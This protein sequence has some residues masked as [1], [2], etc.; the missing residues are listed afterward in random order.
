MPYVMTIFDYQRLD[1]LA[2]T[3]IHL[4]RDQ[5]VS[6]GAGAPEDRWLR[7]HLVAHRIL[8]GPRAVCWVQTD[9]VDEIHAD[10]GA[11][12]IL[13][14]NAILS[15]RIRLVWGSPAAIGDILAWRLFCADEWARQFQVPWD[16]LGRYLLRTETHPRDQSLWD[17][18]LMGP[19]DMMSPARL[20]TILQ[21]AYP[22][23]WD[24]WVH[25]V[26]PL[27]TIASL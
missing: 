17:Q 14:P 24:R 21:T 3:L 23:V 12:A 11:M 2:Q 26:G 15:A 4:R 7:A 20:S 8:Q 18:Y 1:R 5:L 9:N 16:Q 10:F 13:V 27:Y 22:K 19:S 6:I 25:Q